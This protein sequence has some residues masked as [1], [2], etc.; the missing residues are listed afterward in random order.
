MKKLENLDCTNKR[1]IVRV[2]LNVPVFGDKIIDRSRI[3][4]ILPTIKKLIKMEDRQLDFEGCH[5]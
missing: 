3:L 2:D 4:A 1:I 5:Y